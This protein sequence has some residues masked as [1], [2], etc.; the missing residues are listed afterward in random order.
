MNESGGGGEHDG[1][2][3]PAEK[4]LRYYT[5]GKGHTGLCISLRSVGWSDTSICLLALFGLE[6]LEIYEYISL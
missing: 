4:I 3:L 6:T 2:A 5:C 1:V